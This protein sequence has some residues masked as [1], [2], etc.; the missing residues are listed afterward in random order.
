M[1]WRMVVYPLVLAVVAVLGGF[2]YYY[3]QQSQRIQLEDQAHAAVLQAKTPDQL[4]KVADQFPKTDQAILALLSAANGYFD[5]KDYDNALKTYQRVLNLSDISSDL[6]D[7][8][9]IGAASTLETNGKVDDAI[10]AYLT[11]AHRG[12]GSAYAP[13]AYQAVATIYQ[14]RDDKENEKKYLTELMSLGNESPFA[15]D[16][17]SRLKLLNPP[18][19]PAP[20][21]P[22]TP[23]PAAAVNAV[24]TPPNPV[25]VPPNPTPVPPKP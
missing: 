5:K 3:Y 6:R 18:P 23:A 9:Q 15:K 25:P 8:A 16:A 11:V 1:N 20:A 7:S 22:P 12:S 4:V 24:P 19:P 14:Q 2:G 13:F 21:P 10:Q 17:D